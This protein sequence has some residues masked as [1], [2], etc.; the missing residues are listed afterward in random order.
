[1]AAV[2][3]ERKY[4][5]VRYRLPVGCVGSFEVFEAKTLNLSVDGICL[6]VEQPLAAGLLVP[7]ILRLPTAGKP[8]VVCGQVLW[9]KDS[10]FSSGRECGVQYLWISPETRELLSGFLGIFKDENDPG[11]ASLEWDPM[12]RR[13]IN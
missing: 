1:M 7:M 10:E 9:C 3:G 2:S 13:E 12:R 5:R 4:K 11:P 8:I 6:Q